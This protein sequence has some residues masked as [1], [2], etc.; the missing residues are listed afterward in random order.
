MCKKEESNIF[1]PKRIKAQRKYLRNNMTKAEVILW[2][3]LKGRNMLNHKFRRQH[4]IG[5][6]IVD[7]YCP[8]LNLV[9]EVD[10]ESHYTSEGEKHDE[11]RTEFLNEL[12]VY[13]L[14]FTNPQIK[15][16]LEGVLKHIISAIKKLEQEYI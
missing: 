13:I 11:T 5:D 16:N 9:I 14:R 3:K 6:Y 2:S 7:F 1:N 8:E 15:Q 10:G 12:D 4:G